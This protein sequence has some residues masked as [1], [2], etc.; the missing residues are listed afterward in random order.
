M[1]GK[2]ELK[3]RN[4]DFWTAF[5]TRMRKVPSSSGRT[6][7]W[8]KYP[9]GMKDFYLRLESDGKASRVCLDIQPK[10]DGIRSIFWE[11]MIEL[12]VVLESE[13]G[14][15][16]WKEKYGEIRGRTISR[17]YWENTELNFYLDE[18]LSKIAQYLEEKLVAFDRFYM[19]YKDLLL[20]LAE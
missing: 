20:A 10:D 1:L 16:Q 12:K 9:L 19:E 6:L 13:T 11:Q 3:Q 15:A 7:D 18:D 17:I 8:I 14:P 4:T 5:Q 2:E